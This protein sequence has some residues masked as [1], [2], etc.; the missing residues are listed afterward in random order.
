[1]SVS[2]HRGEGLFHVGPLTIVS[3][4]RRI[5]LEQN[6]TIGSLTENLPLLESGLN[7]LCLAILVSRLEDSV[8]V[9][10]FAALKNERFPQDVRR[11]RLRKRHPLKRSL[12]AGSTFWWSIASILPARTCSLILSIG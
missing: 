2:N 6:R 8:G 9:D 11:V 10:P 5:A 7:S 1:M 4:V 3:E 12:C